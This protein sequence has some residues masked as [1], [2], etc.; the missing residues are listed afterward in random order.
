M[1]KDDT[2]A[3]ASENLSDYVDEKYGEIHD[4]NNATAK[5]CNHV[6]IG[7]GGFSEVFRVE[8]RSLGKVFGH[9]VL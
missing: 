1:C 2:T 3:G 4:L 6:R 9:K 8:V 5:Y 7:K